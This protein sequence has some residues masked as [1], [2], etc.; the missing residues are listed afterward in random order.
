MATAQFKH[1]FL[2]RW[3]DDVDNARCVLLLVE[4]LEHHIVPSLLFLLHKLVLTVASLDHQRVGLLT[5]FAF[6]GL[7]EVRAEVGQNL[8][9]TLD[10]EPRLETH[11]VDATDRARTPAALKQWVFGG[12]EVLPA[13]TALVL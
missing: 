6:K 2:R 7:P 11:Q 5:N 3:P 13:E 10:V 4:T 1:V 9:L 8:G 12:G